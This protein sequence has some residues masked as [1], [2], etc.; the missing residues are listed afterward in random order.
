[1]K[2][3]SFIWLGIPSLAVAALTAT[4]CG[5]SNSSLAAPIP[6]PAYNAN[7]AG[8]QIPSLAPAMRALQPL[9]ASQPLKY[10]PTDTAIWIDKKNPAKSI[11][12]TTD[13]HAKDGALVAF[14]LS[15]KIVTRVDG[16]DG[17]YGV[18]VQYG[19]MMGKDRVDLL[20]ATE[21]KAKKLRIY[22]V[23][24]G[25]NPLIEITGKTAVFE[26]SP[27]TEAEPT[28]MGLYKRFD[29]NFYAVVA[30]AK[31]PQQAILGEYKLVTDG[32]TVDTKFVR[33]FGTFSG[34]GDKQDNSIAS[35]TVDSPRGRV[36]YADAKVGF[37]EYRADPDLKES[38]HELSMFG[39]QGFVGRHG[40]LA[41]AKDYVLGVE[42]TSD[43]AA[44]HVYP[45][46][47]KGTRADAGVIKTG[48][49]FAAGV[50]AACRPMGD[51]FPN[52]IVAVTSAKDKTV[53]IYDWRDF[54]KS[55]GVKP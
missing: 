43:G 20:V 35:I 1:M 47:G 50:E 39:T 19:Y 25:A 22:K 33:S 24:G 12:F 46:D 54:A 4:G 18:D 3:Q 41:I 27:A 31:G 42:Q 45:R 6:P 30:R 44:L 2:K 8:Q 21:T 29:G 32:K 11:V 49:D 10:G 9:V 37:R 36:Y 51:K 17:C 15:G 28:A 7:V 48:S 34:E 38:T 52:G 13:D 14:D 23:V 53:Q 40:A 16:M 5:G 26:K 55:L